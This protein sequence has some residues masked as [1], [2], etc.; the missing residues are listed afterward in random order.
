MIEK[1]KLSLF[2]TASRKLLESITTD[3]ILKEVGYWPS[4]YPKIYW[5]LTDTTDFYTRS[6]NELLRYI[7]REK[8]M[9]IF[10]TPSRAEV[11]HEYTIEGADSLANGYYF[12]FN[13]NE[14][15]SWLQIRLEDKRV[16]IASKAKVIEQLSVLLADE[17]TRLSLKTKM[18]QAD[19]LDY[20]Y[21][22]SNGKPC[23]VE[24]N[25]LDYRHQQSLL[26]SLRFFDSIQNKEPIYHKNWWS[27]LQEKCL[28]YRYNTISKNANAWFYVKS[29][30]NF[31]VKVEHNDSCRDFI[32]QSP[33][34]DEEITSLVIMPK[35]NTKSVDFDIKISVPLALKVWYLGILYLSIAIITFGAV[36]FVINYNMPG[37][38]KDEFING[39]IYAV[40]AGVIATRGWLMAEEQVLKNIS[41][42][43]TIIIM[44]LVALVI[45]LAFV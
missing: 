43:Y 7:K 4:Q 44:V 27:P 9:I 15:L 13:A 32:D 26:L 40:I 20:L 42:I 25:K 23:F 31:V 1:G 24:Y 33:S 3:G 41:N 17:I 18:Q 19:I 5:L 14:R 38:S 12:L 45:A 30:S 2:N 35:G 22:N 21:E 11:T 29:P 10:E 34:N 8:R 37:D 16:S 39:C 6:F 36:W 28:T